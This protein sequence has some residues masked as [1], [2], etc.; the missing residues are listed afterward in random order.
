LEG[1]RALQTPTSI[2]VIKPSSLGDVVH[3]MPAVACVKRRWPQARLSWLVNPEWAPIL[4]E[5]QDVNEVI[6]FPRERFRGLSGIMRLPGWIRALRERVKPDITLDFQG[7]FRSGFIARRSGGQV[8]GTSDSREFAR[9]FHDHVVPVPPRHEPL[10]SVLRC[11]TL[12]AALGC[13]T[14]GP[15]AWRLPAGTAPRAGLPPRFVLLHPFSRGAGKSLSGVE[16]AAF[17]RALA[18][19]PVVLAGRADVHAPDGVI[20]LLNATTLPELCWLVRNAAF[21]V[22]VDSGPMHIAAA[23]TGRLL[24]IH[25][26][27][28]PRNVGPFQPRAWV[29]KDGRIGRVGDFPTAEPCERAALGAWTAETLQSSN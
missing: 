3:A 8:W 20:N 27:S 24:A 15:P 9:L 17:C 6:E 22:S 26:W 7:L 14:S 4:A 2:L 5:N 25:T 13:D 16:V 18:P 23:L 10:H 19:T 1:L 29:W 11:L 21:T 28:D 12:A